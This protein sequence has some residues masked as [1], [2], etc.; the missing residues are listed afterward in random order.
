MGGLENHGAGPDT[1]PAQKQTPDIHPVV[2]RYT[3]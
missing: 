3:D 1:A 2:R